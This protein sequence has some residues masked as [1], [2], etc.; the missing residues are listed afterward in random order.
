M[1]DIRRRSFLF[2]AAV[3]AA[4]LV[5]PA[6][7]RF[8]IQLPPKI[9]VPSDARIMRFDLPLQQMLSLQKKLD[10]QDIALSQ[11]P[12]W[13]VC[14]KDWYDQ[15]VGTKSNPEHLDDWSPSS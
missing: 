2:G 14:D 7:K 5:V 4:A 10:D 13:V 15:I 8:F 6:P 11:I 9:I 12:R 3:T 1:I